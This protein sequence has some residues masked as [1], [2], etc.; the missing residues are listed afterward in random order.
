VAITRTQKKENVASLKEAIEG[1]KSLVVVHYQGLTVQQITDLRKKVR[2]AGAG[3]KVTKNSLVRI[4]LKGTQFEGIAD[5]FSGPTA[6]AYS[7][8]PVAASKAVVDFAKENE[9]LVLVGGAL[10]GQS[11]NAKAIQ[12]LAKLPSLDQLRAQLLALIITPAQR[13][14]GVVQAPAGQVARVVG[15]YAAKDA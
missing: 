12:T 11:M 2:T 5:M 8:D 9:K 13:I 3:L 4:A 1:S 6:V 14:V 10:D 7:Q 15:A